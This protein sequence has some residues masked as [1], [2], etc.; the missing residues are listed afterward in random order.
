MRAASW[1][2]RGRDVTVDFAAIMQRMRRIRSEISEHDSAQRFKGLG[3]DL[4]PGGRSIHRRR[5]VSRWMAD[6]RV[7]EGGDRHRFATTVIPIPGL[8]EAGYLTNETVFELTALPK[9]L[10][11]IGAGP[12][13]AE[14]AQSFRRFGSQV[15]VFDIIPRILGRR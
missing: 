12:I 15:I 10:A 1:R 6:H 5:H 13:G 7:Q 2:R 3:I 8:D 4:Y 11:V 14:L 9:R